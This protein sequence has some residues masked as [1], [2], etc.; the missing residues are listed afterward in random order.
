MTKISF[1]DLKGKVCVITGG[2]GVIGVSIVRA[3][4]S[5]GTRI[6]IVDINE[7]LAQKVAAEVSAEFSAEII[8][9]KANV[10][11]KESLEAAKTIINNKLGPIDFVTI[12]CIGKGDLVISLEVYCIGCKI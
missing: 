6:A 11:D 1:D 7:E 8:G 5:V 3:L 4:A 10:L 2:A 12:Y 9:V